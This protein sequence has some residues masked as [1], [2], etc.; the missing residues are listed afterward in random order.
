MFGDERDQIIAKWNQLQAAWGSGRAFRHNQME[1]IKLSARNTFCRFKAMGYSRMPESKDKDGLVW[2]QIDKSE[3]LVRQHQSDFVGALQGLLG[4]NLNI[5]VKVDAVKPLPNDKCE[6]AV[7]IQETLNMST[8]MAPSSTDTYRVPTHVLYGNLLQMEDKLKGMGITEIVNRVAMTEDQILMYLESPPPGISE[9][10]WNEAKKN[11]PDSKTLCPVPMLG[12]EQLQKTHVHQQQMCDQQLARLEKIKSNLKTIGDKILER[13]QKLQNYRQ[14]AANIA[15][16]LLR[17]IC[18]QEVIRQNGVESITQD[19]EIILGNLEK[20]N[21]DLRFKDKTLERI[22][23]LKNHLKNKQS[24]ISYAESNH[25]N[26]LDEPAQDM[27]AKMLEE[28][29]AKISSIV[30]IVNSDISD[31]AVIKADL[32]SLN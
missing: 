15:R 13:Q 19:E 4:S 22:S 11:N 20:L 2:L 1:P 30:Q 29:S 8:G 9:R 5:A 24:D 14:D 25:E 6:M 7:Y 27:I 32:Q 3:N 18:R 28:N 26:V 16:K 10:Q 23:D 12:F 21:Q 17:V 31:M